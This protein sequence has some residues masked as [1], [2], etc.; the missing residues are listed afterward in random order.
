MMMPNFIG[1]SGSEDLVPVQMGHF[2]EE[3]QYRCNY[4]EKRSGAM[5]ELKY[6]RITHPESG[7]R[8][9]L[10]ASTHTGESP[11]Y[12]CVFP[13]PQQPAYGLLFEGETLDQLMQHI[14]LHWPRWNVE[15]L[16]TMQQ[17]A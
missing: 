9:T 1:R 10:V 11:K 2:G 13:S 14:Q 5:I 17:A 8:H 4:P 6:I 12:R 16:L 7:E 3:P 15:Q